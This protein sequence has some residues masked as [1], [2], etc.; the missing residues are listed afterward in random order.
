MSYEY[1][2]ESILECTLVFYLTKMG[3]FL[4]IQ[5]VIEKKPTVNSSPFHVFSIFL[6]LTVFIIYVVAPFYFLEFA[7]MG[8]DYHSD[9]VIVYANVL[10]KNISHIQALFSPH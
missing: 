5:C 9:L 6:R 7:T 1:N 2:L 8:S 3:F 4:I 10:S